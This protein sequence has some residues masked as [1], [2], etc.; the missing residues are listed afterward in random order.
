MK[1]ICSVILAVM[2]SVCY[3]QKRNWQNLDNKQ[4]S[5]MGI[6]TEKAYLELLKG[7]KATTV[8]VAVI[9]A[10][11]DTTHEDLKAVIWKN[12]TE[13]RDGRDNDKNG[14]TNDIHGWNFIGSATG[15]VHYDN[16]ELV[17]QIRQGQVKFGHKDS[18]AIAAAELPAFRTFLKQK[19]ELYEKITA[20]KQGVK[21]TAGFKSTCDRIIQSIGKT[22]PAVA[23]FQAYD[24]TDVAE[25]RA[26]AFIV[27]ELKK[28][29]SLKAFM[30]KQ[31]DAVFKRYQEEIDYHLNLNF[32]PRAV[33][34]DDYTNSAQRNYGNNDVMGPEA[35]HGTHVAG[36][37]GAVR[38]NQLGINGVA[39]HVMI[40]SVRAVPNGDERDK[41]VAN[42]I[43][44]AADNGAKIINMSFGKAYTHD[45]KAVDDAVKY[46]MT[47]DVLIVHAAGNDD[48]NLDAA[49]NFPNR[50][51]ADGSGLANAWIEV[52]A[53]SFKND[54][55]LKAPFSNYGKTSVD[56]FA[57]GV[58]I[59]SSVPGSKYAALD[60]TSMAAPVVAGLAALIRE[61]YPELTAI[62]VKEIILRSVTKVDH[63]VMLNYRL[64]PFTNLCNT[65]GI[66]NAYQAL[67][68]ADHYAN[69]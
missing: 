28:D 33:V 37:I 41:D 69:K 4:D 42:A 35:D 36:I 34:G 8:L 64:K 30:A 65:G 44:Y 17:R 58:K 39:D 2:V 29:P 66:V 59:N 57:P 3:G 67:Q 63:P 53:S 31:I 7:K 50:R 47:K 43:R 21:N 16:L 14:Y 23:D 32:D 46:A 12:K 1:A 61:Y 11:V 49:D 54:E 26:R 48:K 10:G 38:D 24:A 56:V 18:T 20:A 51:Y 15:N 6:S 19:I 55:D 62:Q 40:M 9:D 13:K 25:D 52:G 27:A 22:N 5:T 60:G 68:L 45:K